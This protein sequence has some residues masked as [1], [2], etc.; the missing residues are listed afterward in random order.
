MVRTLAIHLILLIR[1]DETI[2]YRITACVARNA[3]IKAKNTFVQKGKNNQII[4][5]LQTNQ[6]LLRITLKHTVLCTPSKK[7]QYED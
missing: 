3:N 7:S 2:I 5:A 6:V 4:T 1:S